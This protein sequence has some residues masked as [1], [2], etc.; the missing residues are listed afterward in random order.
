MSAP[1]G[2]KDRM[3]QLWSFIR[4]VATDDAYERYLEHHRA[5]HPGAPAL[6]RRAFFVNE[7]NRKWTGIKRCC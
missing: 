1:A 3:R 5:R 2:V 6:S 7:Q 4:E